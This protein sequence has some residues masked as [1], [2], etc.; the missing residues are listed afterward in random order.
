[1]ERNLGSSFT[2]AELELL[3]VCKFYRLV[4]PGTSKRVTPQRRKPGIRFLANEFN[5]AMKEARV[6]NEEKY[7]HYVENFEYMNN[8]LFTSLKECVETHI[9]STAQPRMKKTG[10]LSK[11]TASSG[12]GA[13]AGAAK[14]NPPMEGA[15]AAAAASGIASD[16]QPLLDDDDA[17]GEGG[18]PHEKAA[19][20]EGEEVLQGGRSC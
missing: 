20:E 12:K 4:F 2:Q 7:P 17:V 13:A 10:P 16:S 3:R 8:P 18:G 9:R 15:A 6:E 14:A 5:N 19:Q 11:G 1:M